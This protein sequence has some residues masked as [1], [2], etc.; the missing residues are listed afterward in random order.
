MPDPNISGLPRRNT[1]AVSSLSASRPSSG[2]STPQ[3]APQDPEAVR[4]AATNQVHQL[5]CSPPAPGARVVLDTI[6]NAYATAGGDPAIAIPI[7]LS[8]GEAVRRLGTMTVRELENLLRPTLRGAAGRMAR[9]IRDAIQVRIQAGMRPVLRRAVQTH[10]EQLR[11]QRNTALAFLEAPAGTPK[12]QRAEEVARNHGMT[13][14]ELAAQ[15]R[16][17]YDAQIEAYEAYDGH[18][19]GQGWQAGDFPELAARTIQRM[20]GRLCGRSMAAEALQER[21][22][23]PSALEEAVED[24]QQVG[25]LLHFA[26]SVAEAVTELGAATAAEAGL[27]G[28]GVG[29]SFLVHHEA[30]EY[31]ETYIR[32]VRA[33][34]E[35]AS[36]H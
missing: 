24:T 20:F 14:S 12:A 23:E 29:A 26:I 10:V 33:L 7:I 36:A 13:R 2:T 19:A 31:H 34:V 16:E 5:M 9:R 15:L 18:L 11:N 35:G 28:L 30:M 17:H 3:A 6:H 1:A 25:E 22:T 21:S 4:E 27:A 8:N 32:D